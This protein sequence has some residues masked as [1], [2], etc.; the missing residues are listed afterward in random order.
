MEKKTGGAV[1]V[2]LATT[3]MKMQ[4]PDGAAAGPQQTWCLADDHSDSV[5]FYS[6]AGLSITLLD[7]LPRNSYT[8]LWFDP[9]K[10]NTRSLEAPVLGKACAVIRKPT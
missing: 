10:G 8:G 7:A 5:L 9:R 3:L 1:R 2:Q 6:L 4:P